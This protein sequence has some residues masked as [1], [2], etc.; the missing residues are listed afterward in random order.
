MS[1]TVYKK[2]KKKLEKVFNLWQKPKD[3]QKY[4][5]KSRIVLNYT[6]MDICVKT[7]MKLSHAVTLVLEKV[8]QIV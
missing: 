2:T 7:T 3:C 8:Q 6:D 4:A 5:K 1:C